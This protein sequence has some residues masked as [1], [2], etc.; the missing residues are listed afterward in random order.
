MYTQRDHLS[1]GQPRLHIVVL[2]RAWLRVRNLA[3]QALDLSCP[4]VQCIKSVI[5]ARQRARRRKTTYTLSF[6]LLGSGLALFPQVHIE[7]LREKQ[8]SE[9]RLLFCCNK[10]ATAPFFS[11][12]KKWGWGGGFIQLLHIAGGSHRWLG[13]PWWLAAEAGH[14]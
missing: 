7:L 10:A 3:R 6:E 1:V 4:P 11:E 2:W 12:C 13:G 5:R 9:S 8:A 14:W